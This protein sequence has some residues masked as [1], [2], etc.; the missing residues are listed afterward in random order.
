MKMIIDTDAGIDDAEAILMALTHPDNQVE[1]ITTVAGNVALENVNRNVC[2]VLQQANRSVPIYAGASQPLVQSWQAAAF[3]MADGLGEWDERPP[4]DLNLEE[5]HAVNALV[6]L[7]AAHPGELTLVALGPLT[8]IAMAIRLDPTFPQ[9]IKQ[10]TF[11]GGTSDAHGNT[12]TVTAEYNIFA[13]PEA[14]HIVLNA[15]P[16]ATMVG[17]EA[18]LA[19][20]IPWDHHDR[21]CSLGTQKAAFYEGIMRKVSEQ[22]PRQTRGRLIPDPLAMAVTLEPDLILES[23]QRHVTVELHGALTRGQTVVN[24][25]DHQ[26]GTPNVQ[27]VRRLDI[28]RVIP[29]YDQMLS[30]E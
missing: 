12:P 14:A 29:L 23:E 19:H 11:M 10:F 4:C 8:N 17:W 22:P 9:N 20:P 26:T 24:Y 7:A 15:F 6:R 30:N 18:T 25:T 27:I 21:L 2:T 16:Q 3:H 13:D 5:E 1:A 28:A